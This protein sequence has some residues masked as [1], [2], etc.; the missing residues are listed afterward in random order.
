MLM[1]LTGKKR[2]FADAVLAGSSNGEAAIAAGYSAKTAP[3]AGSRLVKDVAVAAYLAVNRSTPTKPAKATA[4]AP[5]TAPAADGYAYEYTS[6]P[7][8]FLTAAMN[9]DT[10]EMRMRVDAA[11]A[12]MPYKHPKLGEGGKKD[13]TQS[14]AK[15]AGAGKYSSAEPP[16]LATANGKR[17]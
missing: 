8:S 5:P 13:Q 10:L 11:K 9:D 7:E 3:Q 4:K 16:K 6:D 15:K 2:A 12:L 17:L 1:A 14:A